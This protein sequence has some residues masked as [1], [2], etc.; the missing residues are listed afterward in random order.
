MCSKW[1]QGFP[2]WSLLNPRAHTHVRTTFLWSTQQSPLG[3][4]VPKVCCSSVTRHQQPRPLAPRQRNDPTLS[5]DYRN[6]SFWTQ[7]FCQLDII[8]RPTKAATTLKCLVPA[9]PVEKTDHMTLKNLSHSCPPIVNHSRTT[10]GV[11]SN[12]TVI[13]E[14]SCHNHRAERGVLHQARTTGKFM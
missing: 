3:A 1:D 8:L 7:A 13:T 5:L 9:M 12:W 11:S 2:G 14:T 4:D 6:Q 10:L